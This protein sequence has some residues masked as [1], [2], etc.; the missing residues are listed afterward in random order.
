AAL[1]AQFSAAA[2]VRAAVRLAALADLQAQLD[3]AIQIGASL[4]TN[5]S[6]PAEYLQT[7]ISGVAQ[8]SANINALVPDLAISGQI[9]ANAAI[10]ADLTAKIAAFD[11]TLE[12]FVTVELAMR[13]AVN[14]ALSAS[15]AVSAALMAA[16][17][18]ALGP[19][20]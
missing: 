3:A 12:G 19:L 4:Q 13:E 14:V 18:A 20:S 1:T 7:L 17:Q 10:Q 2:D 9:S 8:V 6:D 16:V 5:I 11:R 15:A